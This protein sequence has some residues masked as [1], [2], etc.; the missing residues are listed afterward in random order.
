M[1][2]IIYEISFR[3][4]LQYRSIHAFEYIFLCRKCIGFGTF[5]V[6]YILQKKK[7]ITKIITS[8]VGKLRH[9]VRAESHKNSYT[10][11]TISISSTNT[12]QIAIKNQD[13]I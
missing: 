12:R 5:I 4:V 9:L 11:L 8:N 10:R 2:R 1:Y 3:K 13:D 7:I 6:S